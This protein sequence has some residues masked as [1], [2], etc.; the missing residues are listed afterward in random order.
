VITAV[1]A[2]ERYAEKSQPRRETNAAG[3]RTWINWTQYPDHG[4]DESVL[5]DV[6]GR[7]VLEL[8]SGTGAN[9]AHLATLGGRCMGVD[10]APSRKAAADW[11]WGG[12][13]NLEFLTADVLDYLETTETEFDVVYS[14]FG[15]VWFNDPA[16]LLPL[17]RNRMSAGGVFVFSQ[18]PVTAHPVAAHDRVVRKW[19]HAAAEWVRVLSD[20]GFDSATAEDVDP[21]V[22]GR[23]GTLLVR[24]LNP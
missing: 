1:E 20:H 7:T 24:A 13:A 3:A 11:A 9:L 10:L 14:I 15:A 4:P 12:Q 8:G 22:A 23:P 6:D 18:L 21:P 17:V 5:G 19:N 2:W 16:V